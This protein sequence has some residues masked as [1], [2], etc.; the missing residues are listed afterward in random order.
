[1]KYKSIYNPALNI[2][3]LESKS[4][5]HRLKV[6][7]LMQNTKQKQPSINAYL[8]AR[9][10]RSS[11]S[12]TDIAEEIMR[13]GTDASKKL[14]TIFQ[15]YGHKSVGDMAQVFVCM[16]RLPQIQLHKL[17]NMNPVHAGQERSTRFQNFKDPNYIRMPKSAPKELSKEYENIINLWMKSYS[18]LLEPTK[19]AYIE[20]FKPE[21]NNKMHE[22]AL[23]AR[24]FDTAR[25][26]LPLGLE[27]SAGLV[28]SARSWA[29]LIGFLR[30]SNQKIDKEL[31]EML[32]TLLT[33][34]DELIKQG[35][36]PEADV[37]IRHTEAN[38]T[39]NNSIEAIL[40]IVKKEMKKLENLQVRKI[41]GANSK[42]SFKHNALDDLLI[43]Y[44]LLLNPLAD[45]S[46]VKLDEKIALAIGKIL[47]KEHNQHNQIGNT[48]QS[49][50]ILIEG[51]GD[52]GGV[53]K[54]L[55]RHRSLERFYPLLM[56]Q[57]DLKAEL[58]RDEDT[59]Y[60]LYDYLNIPEF[61]ALRS[62]Y[63]MRFD[64]AYSRIKK[65]VKKAS[66]EMSADQV[67]EYG[68]YLLPH[69]HASKYKLYG[70]VDDWQ[71][72]IH[73]RTRNGGHIAYRKLTYS[74]LEKLAKKS[75]LWKPMLNKIPRV[76]EASRK[77]F[78]DRS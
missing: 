55:N 51:F 68:R 34:N 2:A 8:G 77:Q 41:M 1:M 61:K 64:E 60:F 17:F 25:G 52:Y 32:Y 73:L 74:W 49:G 10:S 36:V 31:A 9:Y 71:Y 63:K 6:H 43:H 78:F 7:T 38:S 39:R 30:A 56:D 48:A 13:K 42:I 19:Q 59:C 53:L 26:F 28:M 75:D 35:Y 18:D 37:L 62:D 23:Q 15:G 22:G 66:S 27:T 5:W 29:E 44:I 54:D 3:T 40:K 45:T 16:E 72:V 46:K 11:D 21:A 14:E 69:A 65:W 58:N 50:A 33:G 57:M 76:D 70:S 4:S 67:R 12:I 20:Y 47:S 24:T